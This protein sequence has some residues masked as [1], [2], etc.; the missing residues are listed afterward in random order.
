MLL[1]GLLLIGFLLG[2]VASQFLPALF[3]MGVG[4]I[5]SVMAVFKSKLRATY[6]MSPRTTLAYG[7]LAIVIGAL[8]ISLSVGGSFAGYVLA[9]C[10]VF[11]GVL[12]LAYTR[13]KPAS[14]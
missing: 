7:T 14:T 3:M 9:A 10:L 11:F 6:E 12:F 4:V 5:F 8:W 2:Y 1:I 13:I